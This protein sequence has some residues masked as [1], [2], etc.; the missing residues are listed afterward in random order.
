[1]TDNEVD[2]GKDVPPRRARGERVTGT[3]VPTGSVSLMFTDIEG[4][5]KLL[6]RLRERYAV[7]LEQ[8]RAI[9]R[10]AFERRGGFEVDT[11][12]DSFFVAFGSPADAVECAIEIQ[13]ELYSHDWPDGEPVRVRIGIHT[14][15]PMVAPTGYVGIDVHRGARIGA[16]AHGGQVLVSETT[17]RALDGVLSG[18]VDF[19]PLGVFRFKGLAEPLRVSEL[20][21]PGLAT[22]FPQIRTSAPEDEPPADGEPPYK[23]LLRF[24]EEDADRFFGRE[25]LVAQVVETVRTQ[26]FLAVLGASGSGK[27]SVIRA[28][29]IPA[30]RGEAGW[31]T[32]VMTPTAS[33]VAALSAALGDEAEPDPFRRLAQVAGPTVLVVDQFEELFTL[34]RDEAARRAFVS[35][36]MASAGGDLHMLVTLRADFYAEV[37]EYPDLRERIAEHQLYIGPMEPDDVR[38][39]IEQ[40]ARLGG[41]EIAPGLVDLLV[42][43]IGSEPGALPLL[44]HALL[45]TWRRRRGSRM[46]LK[47]YFESGEVRGAIARTADRLYAELA[48]EARQAAREILLRLTELGDGTQDT[49]RRASL[50]ELVPAGMPSVANAADDVLRRMIDARLVTVD[51][52]AAEVAHEALIREWP[53]LR[54]WLL[55]DR[56]GLRTQRQISEAAAEWRSLGHEGSLLF[57]GARLATAREWADAHP[58]ALNVREQAFLDASIEAEELEGR[59]RADQQRRELEAA[60]RAAEAERL[61]AE[62]QSGANRRLRRRAVLLAGALTVAAGLGL[63]AVVFA[64]QASQQAAQARTEATRADDQ[65]DLAEE[66]QRQA[67]TERRTAVSRQL[68]AQAMTSLDALDLS[69]LLSLEGLRT[70]DTVEARSSLL[71]G[72]LEA[73]RL[74]SYIAKLP[75]PTNVLASADQRVLATAQRDGTVT[76]WDVVDQTRITRFRTTAKSPYLA[77]MDRGGARVVVIGATPDGDMLEVWDTQKGEVVFARNDCSGGTI[78]ADGSLLSISCAGGGLLIEITS[79]D[80]IEPPCPQPYGVAAHPTDD[81]LAFTCGEG[82]VALYD[83]ANRTVHRLV[84]ELARADGVVEFS[85]NG[86]VLVTQD[87]TTPTVIVWDVAGRRPRARIVERDEFLEAQ[88]STAPS[89]DLLA[90]AGNGGVDLW[91]VEENKLAGHVDCTAAR[92]WAAVMFSGDGALIAVQC[93][94]S[95][96][97]YSLPGLEVSATLAPPGLNADN[98]ND[99]LALLFVPGK[100]QVVTFIDHYFGA[101][102]DLELWDL[103]RTDRLA[104]PLTRLPPESRR[105]IALSGDFSTA[106]VAHGQFGSSEGDGSG[107]VINGVSLMDIQSGRA[108]GPVIPV[109]MREP[110]FGPFAVFSGDSRRVAVGVLQAGGTVTIID[111]ATRA[112]IAVIDVGSSGIDGIRNVAFSNDG[113]KLAVG[114]ALEIAIWDVAGRRRLHSIAGKQPGNDRVLAFSPDGRTLVVGDRTLTLWDVESGASIGTTPD[115]GAISSLVYSSDGSRIA[116]GGWDQTVRLWDAVARQPIGVPRDQ[117]DAVVA[118]AFRQD[119][120]M[121]ASAA[122]ATPTVMLWDVEEQIASGSLPHSSGSV[123]AFSADGTR[124]ATLDGADVIAWDVNVESW[125]AVACHVAGRSLSTAEWQRYLGDEAYH[126]TCPTP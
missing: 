91:N 117:G 17:R 115:A 120:K 26:A 88:M 21:A 8:H 80:E 42:R 121:V 47:G 13:R 124:M 102:A 90:F 4:S 85:R 11:Q 68:A 95:I 57:R 78:T 19:A 56:E 31:R 111:I 7:V 107:P 53:L 74:D 122:Y 60:R 71:A 40:P 36:L 55:E 5:T 96:R 35:G 51:E 1:M 99:S 100:D 70:A 20:R 79:G 81:L 110:A 16:A 38:R 72:L 104:T 123:L 75:H 84:D 93:E 9:L 30:L 25:R 23:G 32:V 27:S 22:D 82:M 86:R 12:G 77:A 113:T 18:D 114:T 46:T 103:G 125:I 62:E 105:A 101:F 10:G 118:V 76:L 94:S 49:R 126:E 112:S 48:P 54:E 89:G 37:A 98:D 6:E 67:E 34:C 92:Q 44:S 116:T 28:G 69:L 33:P 50:D 83:G 52:G 106:A 58:R 43:D 14:G 97:V 73:P 24:E 29:V 59:E 109:T 108:V 45:E 66:R 63:A 2:S 87:S 3:T 119:G 15:E 65:R 39:A 64:G 61:R 41:W